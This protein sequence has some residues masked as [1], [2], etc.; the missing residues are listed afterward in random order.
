[1]VIKA[2]KIPS[3]EEYRFTSGFNKVYYLFLE[4]S[5]KHWMHKLGQLENVSYQLKFED[6]IPHHSIP[7]CI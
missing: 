6:S 7:R 1:M 2:D 4:N 3:A 5:C